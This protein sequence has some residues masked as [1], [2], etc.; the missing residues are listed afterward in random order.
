MSRV[1]DNTLAMTGF[2]TRERARIDFEAL[3]DPDASDDE[4]NDQQTGG[5]VL[6]HAPAVF[7]LFDLCIAR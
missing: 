2:E 6:L 4:D 1:D 7:V 5:E 3:D